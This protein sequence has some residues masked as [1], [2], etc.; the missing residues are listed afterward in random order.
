MNE[1]SNNEGHVLNNHKEVVTDNEEQNMAYEDYPLLTWRAPERDESVDDDV[2]QE[3]DFED[4]SEYSSLPNDYSTDVDDAIQQAKEKAKISPNLWKRD[5]VPHEGWKCV[6]VDDLG[7]PVGICEMCG[8]KI[9]R[10]AHKMEHPGYHSLTCGCIC[11]GKME[12]SIEQAKRRE[13][14]FKNMQS[15]RI[16]FFRR[17]WKRSRKGNEY[18][19]IDDHVVVLYNVNSSS[20]WKYSVDNEFSKSVYSSKERAM[21]A[22]FEKLELIRK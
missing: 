14:E 4:Y 11:A 8:Y 1:L 10:Y 15:R 9:I 17:K 22:A 3:E 2:V 7:A 19:K 5:D 13:A 16:N 18:L 12:G 6:G 20:K 21:A